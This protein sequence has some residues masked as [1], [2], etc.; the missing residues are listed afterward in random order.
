MPIYHLV[1]Q[2]YRIRYEQNHS[3]FW[4]SENCLYQTY[5]TIRGKRHRKIQDNLSTQ[6]LDIIKDFIT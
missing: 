5:L 2:L 3:H 4:V 6:D 1:E